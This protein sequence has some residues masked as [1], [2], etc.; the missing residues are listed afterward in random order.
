MLILSSVTTNDCKHLIIDAGHIAIESNLVP[1]EAIQ[2]IHEKRNQ[3]Y[4]DEDYKN[5]ESLMYDKLYLRLQHAQVAFLISPYIT[6]NVIDLV[7]QFIIGDN[8]QSC[9]DALT[10][11]SKD[12][13]HLLERIDVDLQVHKSIVPTA[14]NLA[15]FKVSGTLPT[16]QVNFSDSKYKSLMRLIDVCIPHF[17][18]QEKLQK[19]NM[20]QPRGTISGRFHLFGFPE[21]EYN[22]DTDEDQDER[23]QSDSNPTSKEEL[24]FEAEDGS[25]QV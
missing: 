7:S 2:T 5:L 19:P 14:V 3:Q 18:D 1:K 8:L 15:Q 10:S 16:L 22:V 12:S 21:T 4:T 17:E 6:Y 23:D 9:R 24:F 20:S 25:L 11:K 13:L